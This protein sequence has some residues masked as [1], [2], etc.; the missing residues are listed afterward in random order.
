[1]TICDGSLIQ[2]INEALVDAS[3]SIRRHRGITKP[4]VITIKITLA[5]DA[6]TDFVRTTSAVET[7]FPRPADVGGAMISDDN[8]VLRSNDLSDDGLNRQLELRELLDGAE[9]RVENE[10]MN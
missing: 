10:S 3:V 9:P 7:K 5:P 1:M 8:I 6:E 4:R 2:R